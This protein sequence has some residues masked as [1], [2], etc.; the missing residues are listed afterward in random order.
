MMTVTMSKVLLDP[1]ISTRLATTEYHKG[2]Y[3]GCGPCGMRRE[4]ERLPATRS[5]LAERVPVHPPKSN[6]G[7]ASFK[8][9]VQESNWARWQSTPVLR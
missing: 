7:K 4:I 9:H 5:G 1:R 8:Q 2:V 3:G 6:L